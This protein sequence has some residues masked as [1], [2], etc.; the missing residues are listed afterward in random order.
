MTDRSARAW[1]TNRW[2]RAAVVAV[3]LGAWPA[4]NRHTVGPEEAAYAPLDFVLES[5]DGTEVSLADFRGRPLVINFWATWCG[6]CKQEVPW[7]V[8]FAEKYQDQGLTIVGISVDDT[9]ADIQAFSEQYNV[10]Y[11]MLVGLGRDDV[12]RAYDALMAIPVTWLI[13]P[14]G[15]VHAK[16]TGIHGKDWFDQQIQELF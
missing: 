9:P 10:N 2:L 15:R 3:M 4:C 12:A 5:V 1:W 13:R 8:E 11:P 7:F 14:D 6:P 16:V